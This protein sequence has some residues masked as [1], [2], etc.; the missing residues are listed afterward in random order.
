MTI[1]NRLKKLTT[2]LVMIGMSLIVAGRLV[3]D[4][5]LRDSTS[6][7]GVLDFVAWDHDW[8]S[9]HYPPEKVDEAA[10]LMREAGV[11]WVRMD[12]LWADLEPEQ[13]R[14][15][16]ARYDQIV[17]SL[18]ARGLR[19]LGILQYNPTWRSGSWNQA[20]SPEEYVRYARAVVAHFKD[21][22]R[23]WE[24]WNEPDQ[25]TYW[26]PQDDMSAYSALLK[27]VYPALK[28]EDPD[29]RILVGSLSEGI[30][31]KLRSVYKKAGAKYFDIVNIHPFM[32]PLQPYAKEQ[33]HG[34]YIAVKR[35]MDEF[36]DGDKPIWFTEIGCPGVQLAEKENGWWMGKSPTEEQQAAWVSTLYENALTWPGV[37]RIFWAFFRDTNHYFNNGVDYF[38][39]VRND[40]TKKPAY[41]SYRMFANGFSPAEALPSPKSSEKERIQKAGIDDSNPQTWR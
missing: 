9:H 29:C 32:D 1:I 35:V 11:G 26:T 31:F 8:N 13:G 20:P 34:V 33:L 3:A 4:E 40:F 41:Q 30:P 15:E 23:Y 27:K 17:A 19:V 10:D 28:S 12:F 39:L 6:P 18:Q 24:I 16:F 22:V 21:R 25:N 5:D 38:G 36:K 2:V 37:Q 7:F 14:F